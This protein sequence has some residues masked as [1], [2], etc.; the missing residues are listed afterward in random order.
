MPLSA[1]AIQ[2]QDSQQGPHALALSQR[3]AKG[4][5]P[6]RCL[7]SHTRHVRRT[8]HGC[9][10]RTWPHQLPAEWWRRPM[11][12][13]AACGRTSFGQPQE[14]AQEVKLPVVLDG[15]GRRADHAPGDDDD[16]QPVGRAQPE[17][18]QVGRQHANAV[19]DEENALATPHNQG[20]S[21]SRN[22]LADTGP[23]QHLCVAIGVPGR[24]SRTYGSAPGAGARG[25]SGRSPPQDHTPRCS[26]PDTF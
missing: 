1:S 20:V 6:E 14:E 24:T 9:R 26:V 13:R 15:R 17:D 5:R 3:W 18:E 7:R 25:S 8:A 19:P 16:R 23:A 2:Q 11:H 12:T 10:Q 22:H 4:A 21:S